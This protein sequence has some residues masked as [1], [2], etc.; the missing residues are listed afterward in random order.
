MGWSRWNWPIS[1]HEKLE[2]SIFDK[3]AV[4]LPNCLTHVIPTDDRKKCTLWKN[5]KAVYINCAH[6]I[7]EK[8]SL[9]LTV[10]IN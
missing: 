10:R 8:K 7:I 6:I 1:F 3:T 9:L 5:A 4:E 2:E